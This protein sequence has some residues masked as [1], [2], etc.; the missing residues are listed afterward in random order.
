MENESPHQLPHHSPVRTSPRHR[1]SR[2]PSFGQLRLDT[3]SVP[4]D[5]SNVRITSPTSPQSPSLTISPLSPLENSASYAAILSHTIRRKWANWGT[6]EKGEGMQFT[7]RMDGNRLWYSKAPTS[8]AQFEE[9]MTYVGEIHILR[10]QSPKLAAE[11]IAEIIRN[12]MIDCIFGSN[13]IE[14]AG[15]GLD[16]TRRICEAIFREEQIDVTACTPEYE[17]KLEALVKSKMSAADAA[18][19]ILRSRNE[20]VQHARAMQFITDAL[21]TK[22][23]ELSEQLIKDTHRILVTNVDHPKYGTSWRRYGGIYRNKVAQPFTGEMG[24]E[25][26]AG[27][28]NFTASK[29]VP[30]AMARLVEE[31]NSQIRKSEEAGS[32]DPYCLAAKACAEFVMIHPFLDGNGRT[33]RL[34]LNALL[35]KYAG[36][37]VPIGE[38]DE[39]REEYLGIKR[40]YGQDCE[41]EGEFA[42]FVLGRATMRLKTMRNK[43]KD[44]LVGN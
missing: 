33:C 5:T 30:T 41:G 19:H 11:A 38:H 34:I 17:A 20:V 23:E 14:R 25:V 27:N 37:V 24:A 43:L 16:E 15:L 22:G 1:R 8:K 35:L 36:I 13:Y 10:Q 2:N 9:A 6:V 21:V 40:R 29:R 32:L 39:E 12:D 28:T 42:S 31:T 4:R 7:I 18:I 3:S 26:N 44:L